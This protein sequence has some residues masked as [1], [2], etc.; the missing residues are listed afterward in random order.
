MHREKLWYKVC[1]GQ[2]GQ[3]WQRLNVKRWIFIAVINMSKSFRPDQQEQCPVRWFHHV[4]AHDTKYSMGESY[5][6][7]YRF[8]LKFKAY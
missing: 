1:R 6:F 3:K 7:Q 5:N 4:M 2:Q 8:A